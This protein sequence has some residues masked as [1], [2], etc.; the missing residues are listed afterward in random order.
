[1]RTR[2]ALVTALL[3]ALLTATACTAPP[4]VERPEPRTDACSDAIY[5]ELSR[6]HPDSLSDRA[7]ERL[8]QLEAACE[9]G[10]SRTDNVDSAIHGSHHRDGWI[11]MP[12][13][14]VL[15]TLMWLMMGGGF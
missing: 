12:T 9:R 14:M 4:P 13:M 1:M 7:W 8:Q 6:E 3:G 10:R 15:G 11:W 2:A 5:L